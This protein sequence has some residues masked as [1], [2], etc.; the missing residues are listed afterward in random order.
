M[1][2]QL[3]DLLTSP[4]FPVFRGLLPN[5]GRAFRGWNALFPVAAVA[6]TLALAPTGLDSAVRT[7]FQVHRPLGG[8]DIRWLYFAVGQVWHV[9]LGLW[10]FR[11]GFRGGDAEKVAGGCAVLQSLLAVNIIVGSLKVITGRPAPEVTPDGSLFFRFNWADGD[12]MWPSGHT[13]SA[14]AAAAA[15]HTFYGAWRWVPWAVYPWATFIGLAMLNGLFH[16]ASDVAAG[17]LLGIPV[18]IQVGRGFRHW[19][20]TPRATP[21]RR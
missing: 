21:A 7:F 11:Q 10:I 14:F 15:L 20:R 13:A 6:A 5:L 4:R 3:K 18:G 12:V 1:L 17:V 16:W 9:F 2:Q 19:R 8:E